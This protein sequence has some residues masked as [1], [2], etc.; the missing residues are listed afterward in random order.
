M[1]A[2]ACVSVCA[3]LSL[4]LSLSIFLSDSL[5]LSL[6]VCCMYV[7]GMY[8]VSVCMRVTCVHARWATGGMQSCVISTHGSA[9]GHSL[10]KLKLDTEDVEKMLVLLL[11]MSMSSTIGCELMQDPAITSP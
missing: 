8:A 6:S 4:A 7:S 11:S 1:Y 2:C 10:K 9:G 5:S 3:C